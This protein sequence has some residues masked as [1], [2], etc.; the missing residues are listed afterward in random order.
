MEQ[1][2]IQK[3]MQTA[4]ADAVIYTEEAHHQTL[5]FTIGNLL[6]VDT[7][8]SDLHQREL[9]Q[10]H[11]SEEIFTL[12]NLYGAYI[13]EIFIANAGGNWAYND[14]DKAAPFIYVQFNDKEFPFASICYHKIMH[15]NSV[16]LFGYVKLAL[17]NAQQ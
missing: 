9:A 16:S 10:S 2:E 3:L 8:L 1:I 11:T 14:S 7:I 13:G 12:C 15:D 6:L 5:D 4:A 17:A